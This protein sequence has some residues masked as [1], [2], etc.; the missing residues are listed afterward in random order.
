MFASRRK[1]QHGK[2]KNKVPQN[3]RTKKLPPHLYSPDHENAVPPA[4]LS[5]TASPFVFVATCAAQESGIDPMTLFPLDEQEHYS[6]VHAAYISPKTFKHS[7]PKGNIPEVAF[8]GRSNAGKSSLINALLR[9]KDLARCSKQPGRTQQ[10]NYFGMFPSSSITSPSE[11]TGYLVDLPG[12]GFA[13]APEEKVSAWQETTQEFLLNRRDANA[14]KRLFLLVDARRGTSQMDRDVMGWL[15]E[16]SIP[17]SVV[18]TKAD[19]VSRPQIVRFVNDV[20]MRHHSQV[21][22]Q[23]GGGYQGPVVHVTSARDGHGVPELMTSIQT[24][25]VAQQE[26]DDGAV[27]AE[28]EGGW[29]DPHDYEDGEEDPNDRIR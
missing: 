17:Y 8:L 5:A 3:P 22:G 1:A 29:G 18:L 6:H 25:F 14:M 7:L 2:K 16:A 28:M 23:D 20:C 9:N 26:Q 15:D 13:K 12:Y 11:A 4:Y 10:V 24:E 19:R 21:Y 27:V